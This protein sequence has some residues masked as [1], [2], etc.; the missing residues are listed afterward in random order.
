MAR[1]NS[2]SGAAD[3]QRLTRLPFQRQTGTPAARACV[4]CVAA[5]QLTGE[6]LEC[7]CALVS[8]FSN[9]ICRRDQG[10]Q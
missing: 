1:P 6:A 4:L 9:P 2:T 10:S 8:L 7:C 3:G 5:K